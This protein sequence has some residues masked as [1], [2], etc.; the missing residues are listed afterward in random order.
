MAIYRKNYNAKHLQEIAVER[1]E[2]IVNSDGVLCTYT[3]KH[4]GRSPNAKYIVKDSVTYDAIDWNNNQAMV[5][6]EFDAL[7]EKFDFYRQLKE[8]FSQDVY[9]VRDEN[10][11]LPVKIITEYAKHSLFARNMFIPA[12]K[13]DFK[14][15]WDCLLYTSPSPRD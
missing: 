5:G 14:P 2:G 3:G 8:T 12:D 4:T 6:P 9:A 11:R 1:K 7:Y 15:E 10:F 13:N